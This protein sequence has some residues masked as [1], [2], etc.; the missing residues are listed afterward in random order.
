VDPRR[1][2]AD[3]GLAAVGRLG[4]TLHD[5]KS[6]LVVA[7]RTADNL[8]VTSGIALLASALNYALILAEN[9]SWGSPYPAPVGAMYGAVGLSNTAASAGQ[10]AL[11]SEIG[12][13]LVSNSAVSAGILSYDFFFPTSLA[14]GSIQEVGTLGAASLLTPALSGALISGSTYTSLTVSGVVGAIPSGAS[15]T[16]GYGAGTTQVVTTSAPVTIGAGSISVTSFVASANFAAG[17]LVGYIPGTLI[18]RAV[19][20][21]P[22]VK[23]SAQT[24]TLNLSLTLISG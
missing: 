14:N 22:V 24:M 13:A 15:L 4:L 12:R 5:A 9:V 6:G 19:L 8:V 16:V 1:L 3:S 17:A 11:V 10:T 20:G 7:H 18:D 23:T 2:S 21:S